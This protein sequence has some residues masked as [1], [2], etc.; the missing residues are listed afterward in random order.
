MNKDL[1]GQ[2]EYVNKKLRCPVCGK[3][4]FWDKTF[5]EGHKYIQCTNCWSI[6]NSTLLQDRLKKRKFTK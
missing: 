5:E 4:N 3:Y 2:L 1:K 6:I